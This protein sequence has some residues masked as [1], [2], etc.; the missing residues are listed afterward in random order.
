[1]NPEDLF[2]VISKIVDNRSQSFDFSDKKTALNVVD[3]LLKGIA[4]DGMVT[5]PE[6]EKLREYVNKNEIIL[7]E[8]SEI[9]DILKIAEEDNIEGKQKELLKD[10]AS[11]VGPSYNHTGIG[12]STDRPAFKEEIM[13]N[14][15][16][17]IEFQGKYFSFTG[18]SEISR[19]EF[20]QA[21]ERKGG[22]VC[23]FSQQQTD[24]LILGSKGSPDYRT[25]NRGTKIDN[26]YRWYRKNGKPQFIEEDVL[27]QIFERDLP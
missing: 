26:G 3:G 14:D 25:P 19:K 18:K 15:F 22:K 10:I 12:L 17:D 16:K 11:I 9:E 24:Y 5:S 13:V 27:Q 23:P 21:I 6:I 2:G 20:E 8:R 7:K 4:C 1:M